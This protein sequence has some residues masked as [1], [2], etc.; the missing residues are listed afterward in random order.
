[1]VNLIQFLAIVLTALSMGVHFGTWATE[2]PIRRTN[3]GALFT[4]VHQG[5]DA[6]AS[7]V[8]PILGN[9][10]VLFVAF[11]A[12]L[13]RDHPTAFALA[14]LGLAL[15]ISD[16]VVTLKFNVPL[17]KEVQKWKPETPPADWMR[18]RDRWEKFHTVRTILIVSGFGLYAASI[19]FFRG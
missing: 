15:I 8:M 2:T 16:M 5:R 18:L 19:L 6:V 13:V 12:F 4:E 1:M 17:N 14:L 10:A 11:G 7:R 3:S 9:A